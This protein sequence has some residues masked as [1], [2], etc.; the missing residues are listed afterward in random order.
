MTKQ[1]PN[2]PNPPLWTEKDL[3]AYLKRSIAGVRKER[4][5]GGGPV[6]YRLRGGVRYREEDIMAYLE[7]GR[8]K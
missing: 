4:Q 3:A 1:Y 8:T 6:Y 7:K 2:P 5:R